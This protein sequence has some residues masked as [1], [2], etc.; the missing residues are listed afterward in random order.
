MSITSFGQTRGQHKKKQGELNRERVR[1]FFTNNP[2]STQVRCQD[3]LNLS[4]KTVL[5]HVKA[6][7]AEAAK[8]SK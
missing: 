4:Q 3:A 2:D 6:L 1:R 7:R 5:T 8:D